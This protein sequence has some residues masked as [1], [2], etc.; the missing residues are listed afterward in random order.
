MSCIDTAVSIRSTLV[1][2]GY[3]GGIDIIDADPLFVP[4]PG[5]NFYL[6]HIETGQPETSPAVD[7]GSIPSSAA[8]LDTR[9][10][11]TDSV[12]DSNIVDLGYH[13][14][15]VSSL[16]V[17]RGTIADTL[18]NYRDVDFLPFLDD[19]GTLTDPTLPLLFYRV[20]GVENQIMVRKEISEDTLRLDYI[21]NM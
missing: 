1:Q 2:D 7:A 5:G 19:P 6:S 18:S 16:T 8:A 14:N 4:G 3:P 15:V 9:T 13:Y 12:A 21:G 17:L 11:R 10:T 20:Q